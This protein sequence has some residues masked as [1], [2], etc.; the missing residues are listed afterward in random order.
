[1]ARNAAWGCDSG[2]RVGRG[3]SA[4]LRLPETP[5]ARAVLS[6]LSVT[7][8]PSFRGR[9]DPPRP[10]RRSTGDPVSRDVARG[11][12]LRYEWLGTLWSRSG[13]PRTYPGP[14][15]SWW[16][17]RRR[18]RRSPRRHRGCRRTHGQRERLR[19]ATARHPGPRDRPLNDS[20][21]AR[22]GFRPA[23]RGPGIGRPSHHAE[24]GEVPLG[25]AANVVQP[26]TTRA[27]QERPRSIRNVSQASR[28]R[29]PETSR[30][31]CSR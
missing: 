21:A 7:R 13:R 31:V 15:S 20:R 23:L 16:R 4:R 14:A 25:F 28:S 17:Q 26:V 9:E 11:I 22:T 5:G 30:S 10:W 27:W 6:V 24:L 18:P 2:R 12:I 29:R 19:Y 8:G 3:G 1:M